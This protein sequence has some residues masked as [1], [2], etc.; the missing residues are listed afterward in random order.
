MKVRTPALIAVPVLM[1]ASVALA[2]CTSSQ[3]TPSESPSTSA[4]SQI[5]EVDACKELATILDPLLGNTPI[6][7][8]SEQQAT[9][10]TAEKQLDELAGQVPP[11]LEPE[12][13]QLQDGLAGL[14]SEASDMASGSSVSPST[15]DAADEFAAEATALSTKCSALGVEFTS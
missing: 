1:I 11:E 14:A 8:A 13:S 2:G 12:F 6:G 10:A 9:Y 4:V 5:S 7:D 3:T 15:S